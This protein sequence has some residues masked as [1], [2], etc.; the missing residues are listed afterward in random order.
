[1]GNVAATAD[2]TLAW[3]IETPTRGRNPARVPV[4]PEVFIVCNP[5]DRFEYA[6]YGPV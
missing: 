6:G 3:L 4:P 5:P 1:M 2:L